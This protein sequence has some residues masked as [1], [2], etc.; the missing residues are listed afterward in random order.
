MISRLLSVLVRLDRCEF[1]AVFLDVGLHEGKELFIVGT[2][3][4]VLADVPELD[5]AV[6]FLVG[7]TVIPVLEDLGKLGTLVS[8]GDDDELCPFLRKLGDGV[9]VVAIEPHGEDIVSPILELP[10]DSDGTV[11]SLVADNE[12]GFG[13]WVGGVLVSWHDMVLLFPVV[14]VWSIVAG[15]Q[16]G[17]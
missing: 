6:G 1:L 10:S 9:C 4:F 7:N 16:L 5:L 17:L 11:V 15:F 13:V 14:A 2:R 8:C 12:D 3:V